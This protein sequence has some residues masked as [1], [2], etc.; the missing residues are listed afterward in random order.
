MV[1]RSDGWYNSIGTDFVKTEKPFCMKKLCREPYAVSL[2]IG[3]I[4][5]CVVI[6]PAAFVKFY[7]VDYMYPE[8]RL[9]KH[10]FADLRRR[11]SVGY[12]GEI[13]VRHREIVAVFIFVLRKLF[14]IP[15]YKAAEILSVFRSLQ[16]F[17]RI[18]ITYI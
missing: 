2:E 11:H 3:E 17:F 12:R 16:Y 18:L 9:E 8:F 7:P 1:Q 14:R 6:L 5:A 10:V 4:A 15:V 13:I